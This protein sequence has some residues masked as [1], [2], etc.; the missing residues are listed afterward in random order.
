MSFAHSVASAT[1]RA[2]SAKFARPSPSAASLAARSASSARMRC[3]LAS[4]DASMCV[5]AGGVFRTRDLRRRGGGGRE[6]LRGGL[7]RPVRIPAQTGFGD[8][9][10]AALPQAQQKVPPIIVRRRRPF[11][12]LLPGTHRACSRSR[13]TRTQNGRDRSCRPVPRFSSGHPAWPNTR[14]YTNIKCG[15]IAAA[16]QGRAVPTIGPCRLSMAAKKC[17]YLANSAL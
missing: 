3:W 15:K 12:I 10:L 2:A 11:P 14:R 5:R 4:I 16:G 1:V 7:V 17:A 9:S 13:R 8:L 6:R